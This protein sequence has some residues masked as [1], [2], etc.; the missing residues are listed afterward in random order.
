LQ[1]NYLR[2]AF[3]FREKVF[4]SANSVTETGNTGRGKPRCEQT[5][6]QKKE[7]GVH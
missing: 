5:N 4:K 7:D 6:K 1:I 3:K 2:L